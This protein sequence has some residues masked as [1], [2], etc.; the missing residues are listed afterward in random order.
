M[1]IYISKAFS[2]NMGATMHYNALNELVGEENIY[3]IDLRPVSPEK[4]KNY[5]C[6]GK[7]KSPFERIHRWTQGN[8]MFISNR[9]IKE[10]CSIIADY[11]IRIVF[12]EDSVFGNLVREIK[13][14]F[15]EVLVMTFYH[16]I[17]ADLYPQWIKN[18]NTLLSKIEYGIGIRQEEINQKYSDLNIVFN[19]REMNLFKNYYGK[20]PEAII[21]L[22]TPIPYISDVD[23]QAS[24]LKGDIK[25]LLFVGNN[26]FANLHGLKWFADFVLPELPENIVVNVVGRGLEKHRGEYSD[27]RMN[28]I[29]SVEKLEPYY[30]DTD[31]VI[32]PLFDG[33][34]MKTKSIE[35]MSYGKI[36]VATKESLV[37]CWDEMDDTIRNKIVFRSDDAKEWISI[38]SGLVDSEIRKFNEPEYRLFLK[39]F[40]YEAMKVQLAELLKDGGKR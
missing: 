18:N 4:R 28:I 13:R 9:I 8:M 5:K 11:H 7:Y 6:Y 16:D 17:K 10:I 25:K 38:I 36:Y 37:G 14:I 30:L 19:R 24:S 2:G 20:E 29:G 32:G 31:I 1:L 15:P 27:L 3:T 23:K 35:A 33:G 40:S 34:G 26:F 12:I 21:P 39:K 22:C